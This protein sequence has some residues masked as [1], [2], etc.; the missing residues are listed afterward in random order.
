MRAQRKI[1][2]DTTRRLLDL[3]HQLAPHAAIDEHSMHQQEA[4]AATAVLIMHHATRKLD[5]RNLPTSQPQFYARD[6]TQLPQGGSGRGD[7]DTY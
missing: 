1:R 7:Y 5:F 3:R 4:W 6:A 2:H